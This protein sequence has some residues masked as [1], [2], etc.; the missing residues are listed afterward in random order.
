MLI[1]GCCVNDSRNLEK[2]VTE[3]FLNE[4]NGTFSSEPSW[5]SIKLKRMDSDKIKSFFS[6]NLDKDSLPRENS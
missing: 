2:L 6:G 4:M 5:K 3:S 1:S